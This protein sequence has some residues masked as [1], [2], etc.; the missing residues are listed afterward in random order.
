MKKTFLKLLSLSILVLGTS[1]VS[2][3]IITDPD[4]Y[5]IYDTGYLGDS[6]VAVNFSFQNDIVSYILSD[7]VT[8]K[9]IGNVGRS[10]SADQD[11]MDMGYPSGTDV[12]SV[13]NK[14]YRWG[15]DIKQDNTEAYGDRGVFYISALDWK[16]KYKSGKDE[17]ISDVMWYKTINGVSGAG[18]Y[19]ARPSDSLIIRIPATC[20]SIAVIGLGLNTSHY[21][22]AMYQKDE[23]R[24]DNG[25]EEHLYSGHNN[26]FFVARVGARPKPVEGQ[27]SVDFVI[28]GPHKDWYADWGKAEGTSSTRN[29]ETIDHSRLA[30]DGVS[31]YYV[32]GERWGLFMGTN[33][34]RIKVYGD[35]EKGD[36]PPFDGTVFGWTN[37]YRPKES[38][39]ADISYEL[40]ESDIDTKVYPKYASDLGIVRFLM[41]SEGSNGMRLGYNPELGEF[42]TTIANLKTDSVDA[43]GFAVKDSLGYTSSANHR[44]Y[45]EFAG[46]STGCHEMKLDFD[47]IVSDGN[48][49]DYPDS[50]AVAAKLNSKSSWTVLKY[51]INQYEG[52]DPKMSHVS[53]DL[54]DSICAN[55]SFK[56][57]ILTCYLEQ[58]GASLSIAN[59]RVTGYDDYYAKDDGAKTIGYISNATDR[60][61]VLGRATTADSTDMTFKRLWQ[62]STYKVKLFTQA[63][64]ASLNS[65]EAVKEAFKGCDVVIM[66]ENVP[67]DAEIAKNAKYLIGYKPFLNLKAYGYKNWN[68]GVTPTNG[69]TD[70]LFTVENNF[71]VHPIFKGLSLTADEETGQLVSPALFSDATKGDKFLQGIT[72]G[73]EPA[74]YV[75]GRGINSG[76][77]CI[78]EDYA[79]DTAK[80]IMLAISGT[81]NKN[82][83][84]KTNTLI[85]NILTYLQSSGHFEAPD[86]N[87]T[88]TGATVENSSELKAAI[89]YDFSVLGITSPII[90]MMTSTDP[91]AVYTLDS[92]ESLGNGSITLKPY[93]SESNPVFVGTFTPKSM[94]VSQVTFENVTF[95]GQDIPFNINGVKGMKISS[96]IALKSCNITG[97]PGLLTTIGADSVSLNKFAVS[98]CVFDKVAN[99]KTLIEI[100]EGSCIDFDNVSFEENLFRETLPNTWISWKGRHSNT[101]A[102]ADTVWTLKDASRSVSF[103]HNIFYRETPQEGMTSLLE[104]FQP[105]DTTQKGQVSVKNNIFFN[106]GVIRMALQNAQDSSYAN[107]DNNLFVGASYEMPAPEGW[108]MTNA[109]PYTLDSLEMASIFDGG[110][111]ILDKVGKAFTAGIDGTYLGMGSIYTRLAPRNVIVKDVDELKLALRIATAGDV[112]QLDNYMMSDSD[113]IDVYF[114]GSG[115]FEYG[116]AAGTLKITAAEGATPK[117][118][119]NI[120]P[121]NAC[122]IDTLLIDGLTWVDSTHFSG[123][124]QEAYAPMRF[125][126]ANVNFKLFKMTGCKIYNLQAQQLLRITSG[127]S[128]NYGNF[129]IENCLIENQGGT[130]ESGSTG[131]HLVQIT[132]GSDY[133]FNNFTFVNNIVSNFHGS[134]VFNIAR[135]GAANGDSIYNINISNNLF[136]KFAGNAKDR[137]RNFI[138]F[139]A[140]PSN[141]VVNLNIDNNIFYKRWASDNYPVA[142]VALYNPDSTIVSNINIRNNFFEGKYYSGEETLTPNPVALTNSTDNLMVVDK[143][144][145]PEGAVEHTRE[146]DLFMSSLNIDHVFVKESELKMSN[147]SPLYTAGVGGVCLGPD[148]IYFDVEDIVDAIKSIEAER[149]GLNVYT[150][151]GQVFVSVPEAASMSVFTLMGQKVQDVDLNAGITC[152]DGL[153]AGS[154]YL[155]RVKGAAVKVMVR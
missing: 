80:Y 12:S 63:E 126:G 61:H 73:S 86:F 68:M 50:I 13:K 24:P 92:I 19:Y 128:A 93:D 28:L 99:G 21:G 57:R 144:I 104:F 115:G 2:H 122:T 103:N 42:V 124:D 119:G 71:M 82:L 150:A 152:I 139:N 83:T 97:V 40:T 53:V 84:S 51:A 37:R 55:S 17:R 56:L 59:V 81:Q 79:A 123:Y 74:G 26:G 110:E 6:A 145:N 121:N 78:Y 140:T 85:D 69:A 14:D 90:A 147:K 146:N 5:I 138:E 60:I 49:C 43:E 148:Y 8:V 109:H 112:I 72:F 98:N 32:H 117:L 25:R 20:D 116:S 48:P 151:N 35:I 137:V 22:I 142:Y 62:G 38:G 66:S 46:T 11:L 108:T 106:T 39:T 101:K 88:S 33:I 44:N 45:F 10:I 96:G 34:L 47:F 58:N 77:V 76:D 30:D 89:A 136:Y 102:W 91:A 15:I 16:K 67:S 155:L 94:N 154:I 27:D 130:L 29:G 132:N 95:A 133:T 70:T 64:T 153:Q 52:E 54:P 125:S 114:L 135:G 113:S 65:E 23:S 143:T 36:I 131:G 127:G 105:C 18:T 118:F 149:M 120:V 7:S 107:V 134:Q 4:D 41:T 100:T 3:A 75:L 31:R 87:L 129:V 9:K 141:S 1:Q 111:M